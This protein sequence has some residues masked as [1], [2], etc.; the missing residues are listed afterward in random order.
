MVSFDRYQGQR[1]RSRT[2]SPKL[3]N[4]KDSIKSFINSAI[5]RVLMTRMIGLCKDT[6]HALSTWETNH[7]SSPFTITHHHHSPSPS[8]KLWYFKDSIKS[9]INSAIMR[10]L[11]TRMVDNGKDARFMIRFGR[12]QRQRKDQDTANKGYQSPII[13]I[14]HLRHQS[15]GILRTV[16]SPL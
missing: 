16:L 10:E 3:W 2:R 1:P 12:Y 5:M 14:H 13:T 7:P 9:F 4:F 15:C 6:R 8:P 11:M